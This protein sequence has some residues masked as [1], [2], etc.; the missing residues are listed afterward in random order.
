M[1]WLISLEEAV[2][3]VL[4]QVR[5]VGKEKSSL[6]SA[7]GRVIAE[8]VYAPINLPPFNRSPLDGY[9]VR[10]EDIAE[11]KPH[12]AVEL[13]VALE[14]PAG[15][16]SNVELKRGQAAK[17]LTGAPIPSGSDVVIRFE[18]VEELGTKIKVFNPLPAFANYCFAGE[19]VKK[20]ELIITK[21]S[22]VKPATIG[23]LAGLG[24]NEVLVYEPPRIALLSTGDE[25]T[26]VGEQLLLGKIYNSSLYALAAEIAEAGAKPVSKE[27]VRDDLKLIAEKIA[28]ALKDSD[29]II[30]TG[31]VSVGDYDLVKDALDLIGAKII[32][33][34][35]NIRPGTPVLF[36]VKEGKAIIGLSGNPAAA[37]IAYHLIAKPAIY[38]LAGRADF[39]LKS[40][41]GILVDDFLKSSKQ[42]RFVRGQAFFEQGI[43]KVE[44][45]G[46]QNPGI[47]KSMLNCNA[48]VD[49]P[50]NT[51]SVKAGTEVKVIL[52]N[53]L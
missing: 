32:F 21:G 44:L 27:I 18:D 39:E 26:A 23:M 25:L 14:I 37:L 42:R 48:L 12:K 9:A 16:Y 8:D 50:A 17:I 53:Q 36:A 19:D 47:M 46:K 6:A 15:T 38:K 33:H 2:E 31:G 43:L 30:T 24:L 29:M 45:T 49:I 22:V 5:I 3:A 7:L 52:L 34:R 28:K 10:S 51:P 20:D 1:R 11:A 13:D 4:E 41:V 40:T 35:V